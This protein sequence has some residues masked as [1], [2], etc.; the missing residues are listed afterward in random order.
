L[1]LTVTIHAAGL[2]A[3]LPWEA[4]SWNFL[5]RQLYRLSVARQR[6]RPQIDL[7]FGRQALPAFAHVAKRRFGD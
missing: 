4:S 1:A 3:V 5:R 6:P 2:S 7:S